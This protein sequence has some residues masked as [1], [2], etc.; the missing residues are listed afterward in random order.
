[1]SVLSLDMLTSTTR[2][3]VY[4][5]MPSA[6]S[7]YPYAHILLLSLPILAQSANA[8]LPPTRTK[9]GSSSPETHVSPVLINRPDV[10][11][12]MSCDPGHTH[13]PMA[14]QGMNASMNDTHNLSWKLAQVIHGF[15]R[16]SLLDTVSPFLLLFLDNELEDMDAVRARA[17]TIR[18][19]PHRVRPSVRDAVFRCP[20]RSGDRKDG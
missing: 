18:A 2:W 5:G 8:S 13:S 11:L 6:H 1:M 16:P 7:N 20:I 17:P 3:T 10:V 4:V 9:T 15:A 12:T 14:G 19:R